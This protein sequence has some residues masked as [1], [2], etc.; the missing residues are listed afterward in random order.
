L[1][2]TSTP[3]I[4]LYY[5]GPIDIQA[6]TKRLAKTPC[7]G[8][9]RFERPDKRFLEDRN[10]IGQMTQ[11]LFALRTALQPDDLSAR[12]TVFCRLGC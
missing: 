9:A 5:P 4:I 2:I 12:W 11:E 3:K 7:L 8:S 6:N 1:F 10:L